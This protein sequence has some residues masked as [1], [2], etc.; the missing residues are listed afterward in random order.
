MK[1]YQTLYLVPLFYPNENQEAAGIRNTNYFIENQM[2]L[3]IKGP[4]LNN[5]KRRQCKGVGRRKNP[6]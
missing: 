6:F 1:L 3:V 5:G 2:Q 4:D